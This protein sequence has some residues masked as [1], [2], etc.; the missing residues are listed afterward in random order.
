MS[1]SLPGSGGVCTH[2]QVPSV[3]AGG[4]WARRGA[5]A[6]GGECGG[7]DGV[8]GDGGPERTGIHDA[9]GCRP[10]ISMALAPCDS[11]M[12]IEVSVSELER[13]AEE[14]KNKR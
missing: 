3:A 2:R 13:A 1:P 10:S 6:A 14:S 7:V 9:P 4:V 12:D 11:T 5:I 8:E